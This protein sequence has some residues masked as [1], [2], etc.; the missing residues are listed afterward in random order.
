MDK[1]IIIGICETELLKFLFQNKKY[2][3]IENKYN[4]RILF[5]IDHTYI[6]NNGLLSVHIE[7]KQYLHSKLTMPETWL[8][9]YDS[10]DENLELQVELYSFGSL[11]GKDSIVLNAGFRDFKESEP[12]KEMINKKLKNVVFILNE[13]KQYILQSF[14]YRTESNEGK[15]NIKY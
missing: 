11:F 13:N 15:R 5:G 4:C 12:F 3:Q 7:N 1:L 6:V 14:E 8:K 10:I 9:K 2:D